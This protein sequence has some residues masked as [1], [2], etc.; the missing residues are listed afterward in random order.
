ME[1]KKNEKRLKAIKL[2][3]VFLKTKCNLCQNEYNL[4]KMWIVYR[5]GINKTTHKF[6][7]C[8][9]CIRSK[10]DVLNEIDTDEY[11]FGI[12]DADSFDWFA[13]KDISRNKE[14]IDKLWRRI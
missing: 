3:Y 9:N 11:P 6:S 2:K 13:K 10:L 8:Q 12:V 5:Y 7:Y 14:H 4:E 1:A